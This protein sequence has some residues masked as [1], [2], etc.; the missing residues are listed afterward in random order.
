MGT[1]PATS[2]RSLANRKPQRACVSREQKFLGTPRRREGGGNDSLTATGSTPHPALPAPVAVPLTS[3]CG[4]MGI[5]EARMREPFRGGGAGTFG[6]GCDAEAAE[7][8]EPRGRSSRR[9]LQDWLRSD[10][11]TPGP[12]KIPAA[13]ALASTEKCDD[14]GRC[15][16][17]SRWPLRCRVRSTRAEITRSSSGC[18][19]QEGGGLSEA[20]EQSA[21]A[22]VSACPRK[23]AINAGK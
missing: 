21:S 19:R 10:G 2:Q 8:A 22:H 11:P 20:Q 17:W 13:E 15:S 5:E 23:E 16:E 14:C 18:E 6:G 9:P 4:D 7:D 12:A 3:V 1:L